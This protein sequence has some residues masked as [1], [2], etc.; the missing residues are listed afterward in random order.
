MTVIAYSSRHRVMA[1]DSR[2]TEGTSMH[3]TSV[4]KLYRLRS[5]ALLGMAGDGDARDMAHLLEKVTPRRLPSRQQIAELECEVLALLVLP[6]GQIIRVA[7]EFR[8]EGQGRWV[9]EVVPITD[10]IVA[11]G[12]GAAFA[13]GA[14]EAGASPTDA[15]RVT[16]RRDLMCALPVQWEGLSP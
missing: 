10:T 7:G 16:C 4:R 1:A 11:V 12:S 13:Y 6:R 2:L 9:G 3:L 14:M 5:G 15:V 8:E